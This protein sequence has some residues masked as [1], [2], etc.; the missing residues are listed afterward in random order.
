MR[1]G[2]LPHDHRSVKGI[3]ALGALAAATLLATGSAG[4]A[5]HAVQGATVGVY[6]SATSVRAST[7]VQG[8]AAAAISLAS[9][10]GGVED[11]VLVVSGADRVQLTDATLQ[12]PLQ[13]AFFFAHY[14]SFGGTLVPDALLPWSGDPRAT[15]QR[16]QPL[17]VQVT[18]PPGTPAGTYTGG[19]GVVADGVT[20]RVPI[21]VKVYPVSLPA[22]NDA[23]AGLLTA[24]HVAAQ[25]YGNT[26]NALYGVPGSTSVPELYRFLA[27]YRLSPSS[28]GYGAPRSESGYQSDRRWWMDAAGE[29]VDAVGARSFAAMAIPISNNRTAQANWIAGLSPN[30]PETWCSYLQ[31]VHGFWQSHDW[32]ASYPYL[33][34]ED[35]PGLAGFKLV[36]R[37]ATA[38]HRCFP[39]G[40]VIVTGNPS[41]E[42]EF[43]WNGGGDD[44][45]AW[46]VLASR[47]YGEY[48]VPKMSRAGRS[49]ATEKL[50]LIDQA[51]RRGKAIWTYTYPNTK[52]PGFTATEPL[53]NDRVFFEWA[54]LEGIGGVLYGEGTTTYRGG[55]NPLDSVGQN[56]AFVLVYPGRDGPI[57]S[58]RLEQIRNGIED[59]E[60][61]RLVRQK[62]GAAAVRTIL[63]SLFSTTRSGVEL[64]CTVGCQLKTKTPFS[65][66]TWSQDASTPAKLEQVEA[67]ALAE[68][69]S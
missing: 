22:A 26:V 39:G 37:Q 67:R 28:W 15:E 49:R 55:S 68:A 29:M 57:A 59:W 19:V 21:A 50:K 30:A 66:P 45:D 9:G 60:I 52:T 10:A 41:A 36:A 31:N 1:P 56:G 43:L 40:H 44:V 4:G 48:T 32:L 38:V 17:W 58:A 24:F 53:S 65:W 27:R 25:T 64:G 42:N 51:R 3:A 23:G 47:Y 12:A 20:T 62:R 63:G 35:E 18:V 46:V 2:R 6:P 16:N 13:L 54:A 33:Y 7:P 69:S 34:G 11:S 8:R 5:T 14:V 61:L